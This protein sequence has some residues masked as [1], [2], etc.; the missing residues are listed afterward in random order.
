[1]KDDARKIQ[2]FHDDAVVVL[3]TM[4]NYDVKKILVDNK[5][6]T[7]VLFYSIFFQIR[8]P[9]DRLRKVS[10][11]LVGFTGDVVIV[12]GEITFSLTTGMDP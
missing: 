1:M 2:T 6:S 4:V 7:D 12:E 5:S 11:L 9:T 3:M 10:T 8:L